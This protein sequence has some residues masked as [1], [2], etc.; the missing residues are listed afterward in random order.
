MPERRR[1]PIRFRTTGPGSIAGVDN[2]DP[3]N[4]EPFKGAAP[5]AATHKAFN[6]LC[7]VIVRAGRTAGAIRLSVQ[8][9]GL[10]PATATIR[11]R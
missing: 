3:T 4:H 9:D 8:A 1:S 11:V 10:K 7:L 6:G 2:G 5:D